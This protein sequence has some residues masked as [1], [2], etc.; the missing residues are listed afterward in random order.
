MDWSE[1]ITIEPGKRSG[2]P[3]IRGTRITVADILSYLAGGETEESLLKAFPS[4]RARIFAPRL[5]TLPTASGTRS[6][7]LQREAAAHVDGNVLGAV[8]MSP[9]GNA[10]IL[11]ASPVAQAK[12]EV[13]ARSC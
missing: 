1:P 2:K 10:G 7:W 12:G 6:C 13:L 5:P 8:P 3:C 4:S 9:D 11:P